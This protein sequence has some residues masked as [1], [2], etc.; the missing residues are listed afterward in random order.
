M[1]RSR[2]WS[3]RIEWT[4]AGQC[5]THT[6]WDSKHCGRATNANLARFVREMVDSFKVGGANAR[7][8]A[9]LGVPVVLAARV[10][11]QRSGK[12]L[13]TYSADRLAS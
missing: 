11:S 1:G 6:E 4:V 13:A 2:M 10:V 7:T 8:G 12:V 9:L 5:W 3:I